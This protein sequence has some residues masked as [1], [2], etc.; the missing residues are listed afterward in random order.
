MVNKRA[1][2]LDSKIDAKSET[3]IA[4]SESTELIPHTIPSPSVPLTNVHIFGV[5]D[6]GDMMTYQNLN[7]VK[8][9]MLYLLQFSSLVMSNGGLPNVRWIGMGTSWFGH[10][11]IELMTSGYGRELRVDSCSCLELTRTKT[12]RWNNRSGG[13]NSI[14]ITNASFHKMVKRCRGQDELRQ[15]VDQI[16]PS[17]YDPLMS[18]YKLLHGS[19]GHKTTT[20]VPGDDHLLRRYIHSVSSANV[21]IFIRLRTD[22]TPTGSLGRIYEYVQSLMISPLCK[23]EIYM[24][25]AEDIIEQHKVISVAKQPLLPTV[26]SKQ[27]K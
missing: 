20:I 24:L 10:L 5:W 2:I 17:D 3:T 19:T 14:G 21:I 8:N 27:I 11:P 23:R 18:L 22:T 13:K 15:T 26:T 1:R 7:I 16:S 25:A 12:V 9:F 6:N 4:K